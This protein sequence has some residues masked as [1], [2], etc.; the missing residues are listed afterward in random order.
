MRAVALIGGKALQ[1]G[2][3]A[4]QDGVASMSCL[5]VTDSIAAASCCSSLLRLPHLRVTLFEQG[6]GSVPRVPYQLG[7]R[8]RRGRAAP[9]APPTPTAG[10]HP[11]RRPAPAW[12]SSAPFE[13]DT[14]PGGASSAIAASA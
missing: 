1:D 8:A 14:A 3:K 4:L 7:G 13:P 11:S 2:G 12:Q 5:K 6:Q 10:R 9:I